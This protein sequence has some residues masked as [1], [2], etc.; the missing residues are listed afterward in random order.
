MRQIH[1][2]RGDDGDEDADA[3]IHRP[4]GFLLEFARNQPPP[5]IANAGKA[6]AQPAAFGV[7]ATVKGDLFGVV[8]HTQQGGAVIRFAV[9]PFDVQVFEFAS[10]QM[11]GHG[12][13]RGIAQRHPDEIAVYGERVSEQSELLHARKLPQHADKGGKFEHVVE[14]IAE[15]GDTFVGQQINVFG[16]ALVGVVGFAVE[17]QAVMAALC[18]PALLKLGGE[19][20]APAEHQLFLQPVAADDAADHHCH[21]AQVFCNQGGHG[22]SVES[23]ERVVEFFVPVGNQHADADDGDG[24]TEHGGKHEPFAPLAAGKPERSGKAVKGFEG[25]HKKAFAKGWMRYR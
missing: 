25:L 7:F 20:A 2:Q 22:L 16:D 6:G 5:V 12:G 9:L 14:K 8:A 1:G 10:D 18:Q 17:L 21:I 11:G 24:E 23:G 15:Q 19:V 4:K 13:Q 3:D